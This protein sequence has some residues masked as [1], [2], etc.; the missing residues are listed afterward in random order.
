MEQAYSQNQMRPRRHT[1]SYGDGTKAYDHE[2][3][4]VSRVV[5]VVKGGRR[6]RFRATVAVGDRAGRIGLGI[7][8]SKDIQQAIQKAQDH[9]AKNI[10]AVPLYGGT[11]GH[12]AQAQFKGAVIMVKPARPGTGLIAGGIVR[13][14]ADLAGIKDIVSKRYGSANHLSNAKAAILALS[15]SAG[16]PKKAEK[17]TEKDK[18]S[19]V[20]NKTTNQ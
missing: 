2:V 4:D 18:A 8:K 17:K 1:F 12:T 9:A 7:G 10:V 20:K 15:A 14:V 6:F 13:T 16:Q 19:S 5:R 11:I 3:L